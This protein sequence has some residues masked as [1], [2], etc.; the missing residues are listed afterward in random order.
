MDSSC[1][2]APASG[3]FTTSRL[4]VRGLFG[5]PAGKVPRRSSR[6][7]GGTPAHPAP[8]T[9]AAWPMAGRRLTHALSAGPAP[10]GTRLA[11]SSPRSRTGVTSKISGWVRNTSSTHDSWTHLV[12]RPRG[13]PTPDGAVQIQAL[14]ET[15]MTS[16]EEAPAADPRIP[17]CWRRPASCVGTGRGDSALCRSS[18]PP[19]STR[20]SQHGVGLAQLDAAGGRRR[21]RRVRDGVV[22]RRNSRPGRAGSGDRGH[23]RGCPAARI[24]H[25]Q[26]RNA[27]AGSRHRAPA[28]STTAS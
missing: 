14:R 21:L 15:G 12:L 17:R 27:P 7:L 2:A 9:A 20:L 3:T 28:P 23:P 25:R 19:S 8:P 22:C 13:Q 24:T 11:T 4:L 16:L 10:G 5:E 6:G 26:G 18:I 1:G